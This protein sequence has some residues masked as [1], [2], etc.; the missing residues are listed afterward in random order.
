MG[1]FEKCFKTSCLL[2]SKLFW[3]RVIGT[4]FTKMSYWTMLY[5]FII[6]K[7]LSLWDYV[8]ITRFTSLNRKKIHF[9]VWVMKFTLRAYKCWK[10]GLCQIL[11]F[12]PILFW[13]YE[14]VTLLIKSFKLILYISEF[15]RRTLHEC[16]CFKTRFIKDCFMNIVDYE[17]Y[18]SATMN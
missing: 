2:K 5:E 4:C 14:S 8:V 10:Q 18:Y 12:N 6:I 16:K 11:F 3:E 1:I 17:I 15:M 9:Y 7:N 13:N